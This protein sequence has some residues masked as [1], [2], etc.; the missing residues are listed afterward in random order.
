MQN[1]IICCTLVLAAALQAAHAQETKTTDFE[2]H[3]IFTIQ[4]ILNQLG[5]DAGRVDGDY[6]P[7]TQ[8]HFLTF[9]HQ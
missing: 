3:P 9:M 6:G 8:P 2:K 4:F 1:S 5:Y 7:R